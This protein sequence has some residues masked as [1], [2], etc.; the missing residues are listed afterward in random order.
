M[1]RGNITEFLVKGNEYYAAKLDNGSVRVGWIDACAYDLPEGHRFFILANG[2]RTE[3]D[4]EIIFDY[5]A[6]TIE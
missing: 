5:C 2:I 6:G 3:A 4:A 1:A